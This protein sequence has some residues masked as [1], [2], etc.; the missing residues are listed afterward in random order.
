MLFLI[1]YTKP[2]K[3]DWL[4]R[5]LHVS[6]LVAA[7]C[8]GVTIGVI[9]V[10]RAPYGW[11]AGVG[12]LF[13]SIAVLMPLFIWRQTR[14]WMIMVVMLSG[15]LMGLWRGSLGQVGLEEYWPL[16]GQTVTL[17]GVVTED[18]DVDK[19]G[20]TVLRLGQ[21]QVAERSLPGLVWVT[22]RQTDVIKR[23][24][25]V[26]I[27][28]KVSEGFGA[29]AA[30]IGRAKIEKVERPVPG[31]VAVGVRD[32]FS[33]RVRRHVAEDEAALGL[34]F[35]LGLRRALPPDLSEALKIAGL[36]HVI[37][38]SGYNLTI[39]VRLSRRL[40]VRVSKYLSALS[41]TAMILGFMALTGL[42]PSMS[43]AGLVAGLSLAAWYYGRTIHPLVLLPVAAAITLLINPAYGWNDL[44]WQLSFA[45][46]AGVIL[47]APLLQRYFFGN[48]QPGTLRQIFGETLSAQLMTLPILVLAFGVISNVALV[49]NILILPLVPLAM[50]LTFLVGVLSGV[51]LIAELI[52]APTEWL[53]G[54]MVW[55]G[56]WLAGQPWAQTELAINWW[57]AA[58]AYALLGAAMW[59]MQRQTR[60]QLHKVN[61]IE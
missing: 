2:M 30:R 25:I 32:W 58:L 12:W 47:L 13:A 61:I 57:Q 6:W 16:I 35:L 20:N 59:W 36:T 7:W 54:Y 33:E 45:A 43:Q 40:F 55:V 21:V 9:M 3:H 31:D 15:G 23:S 53:L 56:K 50:L 48:K 14:V 27:E 42:S 34:G 17:R 39:L 10:M 8:L 22:T 60:T 18:P 11:F 1:C 19:K 5:P 46:F 37:V 26:T 29:F 4:Q 28:G 44:G 52:A 41:A 24:D 38:A 49:A 51:P